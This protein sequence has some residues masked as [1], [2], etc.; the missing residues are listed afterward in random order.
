MLTPTEVV[1]LVESGRRLNFPEAVLA[2]GEPV[3]TETIRR[4]DEV[5][6]R[7]FRFRLDEHKRRLEADRRA[8]ERRD[9]DDMLAGR[10]PLTPEEE[11]TAGQARIEALAAAQ[12]YR[13]TEAR[14]GRME[15][16]LQRICSAL[17]RR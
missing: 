13:S 14:L 2:G 9:R 8:A 5:E 17:E 15:D 10:R 6:E 11:A 16:Y 3:W 12:E 7:E 4:F 1:D